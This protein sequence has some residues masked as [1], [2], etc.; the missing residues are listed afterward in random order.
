MMQQEKRKHLYNQWGYSKIHNLQIQSNFIDNLT[1]K[2]VGFMSCRK[3]CAHCCS[4]EV[5]ITDDEAD[6]LCRLI[7]DKVVE[8]DIDRLKNHMNVGQDELSGDPRRCIF[9]NENNECNVYENRPLMCRRF[10]VSSNPE[11]C[12]VG[13]KKTTSFLR[14]NEIEKM[15]GKMSKGY[16]PRKL[17]LRLKNAKYI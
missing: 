17:Y 12:K 14:S 2:A 3:G 4:Y 8:I 9:L 1:K 7:V 11:N 16:M 5:S 13:S 6:D 15:L 10:L